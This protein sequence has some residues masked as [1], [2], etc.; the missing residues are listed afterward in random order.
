MFPFSVKLLSTNQILGN[1]MSL[2]W[3]WTF[4][5]LILLK[6]SCQHCFKKLQKNR[7]LPLWSPKKEGVFFDTQLYMVT[8][9]HHHWRPHNHTIVATNSAIKRSRAINRTTAMCTKHSGW[10]HRQMDTRTSIK[11][12][13]K[14]T[15]HW[16]L[17][18]RDRDGSYQ[19]D[20]KMG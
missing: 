20:T 2:W 17:Q 7:S 15:S 13:E 1:I 5:A 12:P 14:E 9:E 10:E 4:S 8:N 19:N 3:H 16:S 18:G 6:Q 11:E